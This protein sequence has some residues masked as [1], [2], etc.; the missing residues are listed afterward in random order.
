[1]GNRRMGLGR[2]EALLEAVDR[3]LNLLNTT[4]TNC[5]IT[6]T[7]TC[8]FQGTVKM[9]GILLAEPGNDTTVTSLVSG[10]TYYFG[11]ATGLIG[12][13]D[14]TD[15]YSFKLPTPTQVGETIVL[16][17]TNAAAYA[18]KLGFVCTVPAT[19][20]IKYVV[21]E[22]AAVVE[23]GTTA[24]GAL[25]GQ[26]VYVDLNAT[27]S[28]IG[29]KYICTSLSTTQ[30]LLEIHGAGGLIVAGDIEPAVGNANGCVA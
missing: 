10:N 5:T 2:M 26:N 29:D 12:A 19:Q 17:A 27:H 1:M 25:A 3:D 28:K 16:Y 24:A 13:T 30:W 20:L 8:T 21:Y 15:Q 9:P 14:A 6:T 4:L 18:K 7:A 22:A 23:S 11:T